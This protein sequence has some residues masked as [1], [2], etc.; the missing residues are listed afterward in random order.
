MLRKVF[1]YSSLLLLSACANEDRTPA[2]VTVEAEC[3]L[4]ADPGFAVEG[5]RREDRQWIAQTQETGIQSC[6]WLRPSAGAVGATTKA[7]GAK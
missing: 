6:G 7:T 2:P 4:F 3:R 1:A 5:K